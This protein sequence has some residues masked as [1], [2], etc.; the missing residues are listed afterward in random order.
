MVILYGNV[1]VVALGNLQ[2][3]HTVCRYSLELSTWSCVTVLQYRGGGRQNHWMVLS[4]CWPAS[5]WLQHPLQLL[6]CGLRRMSSGAN[7]VPES[8]CTVCAS[9][10]LQGAQVSDAHCPVTNNVDCHEEFYSFTNQAFVSWRLVACQEWWRSIAQSTR[11]TCVDTIVV[12]IASAMNNVVCRAV[13]PCWRRLPPWQHKS[14]WP[15]HML[16]WRLQTDQFH[17]RGYGASLQW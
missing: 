4:Q 3:A 16:Q 6:C 12:V 1:V 17:C 14:L 11:S 8:L 7:L 13:Q 10:T 5:D 15:M 9:G 2:K